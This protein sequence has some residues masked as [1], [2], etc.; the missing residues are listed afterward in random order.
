M[1]TTGIHFDEVALQPGKSQGWGI[2]AITPPASSHP[3]GFTTLEAHLV[4]ILCLPNNPISAFVSMHLFALPLLEALMGYPT[5]SFSRL[6]TTKDSGVG[7]GYTAATGA[8]YWTGTL[9]ECCASVLAG[10]VQ[11]GC[12]LSYRMLSEL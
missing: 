5:H 4:P 11:E 6:F 2:L 12:C 7:A 8:G 10:S 9:A 3:Y 1:G